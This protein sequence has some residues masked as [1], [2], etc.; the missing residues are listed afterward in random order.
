MKTLEILLYFAATAHFGILSASAMA[1]RALHWKEHLRELPRLI[2]QL[3]W[4]YGIFI[5]FTIISFG[6]LTFMP[7]DAMLAGDAVARGLCA[8]I[9]AFWGL[10]LFV[11]L[12]VFDAKPFLTNR[13]YRLGYHALNVTFIFLTAV[14]A[15]AACIH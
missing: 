3:F 9:A 12:F 13:W 15:T 11:Q 6:I 8:M 14:Y 2:R 5:V 4:V 10:R 1:R 7:A